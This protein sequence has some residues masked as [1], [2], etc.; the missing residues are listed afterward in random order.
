MFRSVYSNALCIYAEDYFIQFWRVESHWFHLDF[1]YGKIQRCR[2]CQASSDHFSPFFLSFLILYG[3]TYNQV[4]FFSGLEELSCQNRTL[5]Q[6][7]LFLYIFLW[8][9]RLN[10]CISRISILKRSGKGNRESLLRCPIQFWWI[11]LLLHFCLSLV[12]NCL[13]LYRKRESWRNYKACF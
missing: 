3:W 4:L 9:M 1:T 8:L 10:C 7:H 6:N 12:R 5:L 2:Y 11:H 13:L